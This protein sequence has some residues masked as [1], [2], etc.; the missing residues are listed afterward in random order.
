[1]AAM[2]PRKPV[3][4]E[5]AASAPAPTAATQRH[6]DERDQH[7]DAVPGHPGP[8]DGST[9]G[10]PPPLSTYDRAME[11]TTLGRSN[12]EVS[13]VG[14]G[15]N[16]FGRRLDLEASLAVLELPST[17]ASRF[18]D[19]ADI[20]GTGRS[21]RILGEA[22]AGPARTTSSS[23]RSSAWTWR[24]RTATLPAARASTCAARVEASL[25]RLGR[26]HVDLYYYHRPDGVTPLDETLGAMHELVVEGKVRWLG[27]SNVDAA[28]LEQ[29]PPS[30]E[31]ATARSSRCRTTT[32]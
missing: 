30:R 32:A 1:M 18:F 15:C 5:R 20:Y 21:E 4:L 9:R 22:L 2:L 23:R 3:G 8:H 10:W 7:P 31:P 25:R 12:L 27:L 11:S 28:H 29:A 19:T 6:D 16:N 26:D 24:A 13:R 17:P 14:L